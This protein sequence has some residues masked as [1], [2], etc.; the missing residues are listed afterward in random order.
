MWPLENSATSINMGISQA[1]RPTFVI[2]AVIP[3]VERPSF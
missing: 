1:E 3:Q 2:I